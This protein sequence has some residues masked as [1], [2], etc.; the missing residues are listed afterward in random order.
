MLTDS[1]KALAVCFSAGSKYYFP[2]IGGEGLD[3]DRHSIGTIGGV[4]AMPKMQQ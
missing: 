1:C 3:T 4:L 2:L